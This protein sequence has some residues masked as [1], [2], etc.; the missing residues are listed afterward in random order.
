[1]SKLKISALCFFAMALGAQ[2]ASSQLIQSATNQIEVG[3]YPQEI[4]KSFYSAKHLVD[5]GA[6]SEEEAARSA[7]ALPSAD[8]SGIAVGDGD[9]VYALSDQGLLVYNGQRWS[10]ESSKKPEDITGLNPVDSESLRGIDVGGEVYASAKNADGEMAVGADNGLFIIDSDGSVTEIFPQDGSRSWAP[11]G[12]KGVGYDSKG[13][14]WF[15]SPQGVGV[16]KGDGWTLFTGEEGL[17]YNDF[18]CLAIGPDD[19]VWFG[20]KIGAIRYDDSGWHYRQGQRWLPGDEVRDIAIDSKGNAWF[21][22]NEGVGKIGFVP[23]TLAEK[24]DHYEELIDKYNRRTEYGYVLEAHTEVPGHFIGVTNHDSDNDGLWTAM[25][26]AGECFAYGA[27]KDPEAKRRAKQAFEALRFL[28]VVPVGGEV[29]QQPG[30]VART[31]IPVP[32]EGVN[33]DKN[34][35]FDRSYTPRGMQRNRGSND[36]LWKVY[37]PR[38]PLNK[39]KTYWYKTDTSSDE[40]DGHYF[41][42]PQYYDLVA[43]T[44]QEKERVREVVRNI[45]DHLIRNDYRLID[46]DGEPTRWSDYSPENLNH[47]HDWYNERGL[48]SLSV[49]SYLTVAKHITGDEKYGEE[50]VRLMKD[51]AYNTNA[52]VAKIQFGVGSGNQSD[53]EM[54]IM[55][56]YNLLKYTDNPQLRKELTYSFYT[57]WILEFP[58]LNPFFNFCYASQG[59]DFYY[60]NP[61][62]I[63]NLSPWEGWLEDSVDTLKRFP[64]D[65]FDWSH[66]NEH[67]IDLNAFPRQV[68]QEPYESGE[69]LQVIRKNGKA[70]PA[71]ERH[72]NHWNTNPWAPNYGG[73][74]RGLSD[75]AVYLLPYY[76]GLYHGFIVEE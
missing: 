60:S 41:F 5:I 50:I 64:L 65:R 35:N 11:T 7:E 45:T 28:S 9:K 61:W 36:T 55:C 74:G 59:L 17:P 72:F 67:R 8:I 13:N 40:L 53:D 21:A 24:A 57:Y 30:F 10:M 3:T 73:G 18:T 49:L 16:S 15:C 34:P 4:S 54:A 69:R 76:M 12:V 23:M 47:N 68:A 25:Y 63:H 27:T 43:E 20:T 70:L 71:D 56:Y 52:M 38:W 39:D 46:H 19:K 37:Y 2:S 58:E 44:E 31:V 33:S 6:M 32:E 75:G 1:M 22:T 14:L 26:G 29:V 48:K 62:G 51:Y 42:Y 66:K